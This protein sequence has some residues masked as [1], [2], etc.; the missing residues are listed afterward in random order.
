M[1]IYIHSEETFCQSLW[2][3]AAL[4]GL[5]EEARRKKYDLVFLSSEQLGQNPDE[6]FT[7][8]TDSSQRLLIVIATSPSRLDT[9]IP[10]LQQNGIAVLLVNC[11][12]DGHEADDISFILMNYEDAVK[13]SVEYLAD[14]G[15]KN[16]ALFGINLDSGSDRIKLS[17]FR[18]LFGDNAPIFYNRSGL[19]DCIGE[20]LRSLSAVSPIDAVISANDIA[21][22]ALMS[23]LRQHKIDVPKSLYLI[24][25]GDTASA[26]FWADSL[27]VTTVSVDYAEL[28]R[29]SI[30]LAGFL[31]RAA[32]RL[33]AQ[34]KLSSTFRIGIT[35]DNHPCKENPP[36]DSRTS[37]SYHFYDDPTVAE[38]LRVE[39]AVAAFDEI[40]RKLI[41]FLSVGESIQS[42]SAALYL[43]SGAVQ[44]RVRRIT[45]LLGCRSRK[46]TFALLEKYFGKL[47]FSSGQQ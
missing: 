31:Q 14:C 6:I 19:S 44:Y 16:P 37:Q 27:G 17:A 25:F 1:T 5:T 23:A 30:R 21:G 34:V 35:T 38:I 26:G 39:S 32:V 2:Y 43:S 20:F 41:H 15:R 40:D 10:K 45:N 9:L 22:V 24:S 18:A 13:R 3:A 29:Q 47:A 12:Y 7:A 28:G 11:G 36:A 33:T 46:E 4:R 8:D 42:A